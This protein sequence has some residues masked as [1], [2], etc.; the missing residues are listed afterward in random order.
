[1]MVFI[2]RYTLLNHVRHFF[3]MHVTNPVLFFNRRPTVTRFPYA[4]CSDYARNRYTSVV[5]LSSF[6]TISG[7]CRFF[8]SRVLKMASWPFP[9]DIPCASFMVS[10]FRWR[11]LQS[12]AI[13]DDCGYGA[14]YFQHRTSNVHALP[15]VLLDDS[16]TLLEGGSTVKLLRQKWRGSIVRES[17]YVLVAEVA[18]LSVLFSAA[19]RFCRW[20]PQ[21]LF[22]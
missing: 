13:V 11:Q 12:Q 20:P 10:M 1:M 5:V 8:C 4:V 7:G 22:F 15:Y 3:V 6:T 18:L 19:A 14:R 2:S 16:T 17:E 21:C 9:R